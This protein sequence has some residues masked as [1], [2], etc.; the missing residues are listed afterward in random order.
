MSDMKDSIDSISVSD[1][2]TNPV[3]RFKSNSQSDTGI[4]LVSIKKIPCKN[5]NDK[6]VGCQV[7]LADHSKVWCLI[8]NV[9]SMDPKMTQHFLTIS[10]ESNGKWFTLAR[11][12]DI[13]YDEC[14]PQQLASFLGKPISSVFPIKYDIRPYS[15]G[16]ESSLLGEISETPKEILSEDDLIDL[17]VP[18]AQSD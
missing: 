12:H 18:P 6:L 16:V 8:G 9:D 1:L 13:D 2:V 7:Q 11:Y 5:L 10:I 3:W 17:A 4:E 15:A 14:G